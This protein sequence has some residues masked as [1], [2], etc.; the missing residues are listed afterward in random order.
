MVVG[1]IDQGLGVTMAKNDQRITRVGRILRNLGLDELPQ[2]INFL[3]GDMSLVGP[4]PTVPSQ[5]TQ[6]Q[7]VTGNERMGVYR[8]AGFILRGLDSSS[9][10]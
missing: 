7:S 10:V 6:L 4:C 8:C 2:L 9:A 5:G 1:A 3:V